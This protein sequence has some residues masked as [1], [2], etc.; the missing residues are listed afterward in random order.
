LL[1][2]IKINVKER[3][4]AM[5]ATNDESLARVSLEHT[6]NRLKEVE[7]LATL[8]KLTPE[9]AIQNQE[10]IGRETENINL[11]I[12]KLHEEGDSDKALALNAD[13]EDSLAVHEEVINKISNIDKNKDSKELLKNLV[14]SVGV[15]NVNTDVNINNSSNVNVKVSATTA[16]ENARIATTMTFATSVSVSTS[17]ESSPDSSGTSSINSEL[18]KKA[19]SNTDNSRSDIQNQKQ[20]ALN[21]YLD[22]EKRLEK[23][24]KAILKLE[25]ELNLNN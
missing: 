24:K 5:L 25:A 7:F 10:K 19:A 16:P 18:S 22:T 1:Y 8:G 17:S 2:P 14:V 11:K 20:R 13:L 12:E 6:E 3:A 9:V 23:R 15:K 4:E 21:S